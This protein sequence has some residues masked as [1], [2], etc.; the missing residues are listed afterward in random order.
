K[1]E[2]KEEKEAAD[3]RAVVVPAHLPGAGHR[4]GDLGGLADERVRTVCPRRKTDGKF[5]LRRLDDGPRQIPETA[6]R[7]LSGRSADG[8]SAGAAGIHRIRNGAP[9]GGGEPKPGPEIRSG[10]AVSGSAGIRIVRRSNHRAGK[11]PKHDRTAEGTH[12]RPGVRE[13]R[14]A[15]DFRD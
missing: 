5:G 1:E 15:S 14:A 8:E 7:T 9:S 12:G 3:P 10:A 11:V 2:E 6:R 4:S 13:S